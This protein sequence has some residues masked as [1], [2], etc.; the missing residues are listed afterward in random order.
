MY[1]MGLGYGGCGY[2]NLLSADKYPNLMAIAL[3]KPTRDALGMPSSTV[4]CGA[5]VRITCN[6]EFYCKKGSPSV[7]GVI[8]DVCPDTPGH[9]S[10]NKCQEKHVD[11]YIKGWDVVAEGSN[12]DV[13]IER[14]QC[15][16]MDGNVKL[17]VMESHGP[18]GFLKVRPHC[19]LPRAF[20]C[21]LSYG[22]RLPWHGNTLRCA[23][24]MQP[25]PNSPA[26]CRCAPPCADLGVFPSCSTQVNVQE[27]G[28]SGLVTS[29]TMSC[30]G[31][32]PVELTNQYGAVFTVNNQPEKLSKCKFTLTTDDGATVTSDAVSMEAEGKMDESEGTDWVA[33]L[34]TG[35]QFS[36]GVSS[37]RKLLLL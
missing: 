7:V 22:S 2:G 34:D 33:V 24:G 27:V 12:P 17:Y 29:V 5:C 16:S 18:V 20:A 37:G 15:P 32:D 4:G 6:S 36:A 21:A 31:S 28:G 19:C 30:S 9:S 23:W 14:V 13:Q 35:V 11:M 3:S 10:G 26:R 25:P 1:W 8:T